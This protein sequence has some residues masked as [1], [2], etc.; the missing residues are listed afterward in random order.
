MCN[1]ESTNN[2]HEHEH[3]QSI[4]PTKTDASVHGYNNAEEDKICN[5]STNKLKQRTRTLNKTNKN[6]QRKVFSIVPK[7]NKQ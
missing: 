3:E 2:E 7:P 4:K 5:V 1:V 6:Q